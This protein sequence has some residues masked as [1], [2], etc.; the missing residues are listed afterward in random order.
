MASM[1]PTE[2]CSAS[3]GGSASD[4]TSEKFGSDDEKPKSSYKSE[5]PYANYA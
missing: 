5:I 2:L 3:V 1:D 4:I